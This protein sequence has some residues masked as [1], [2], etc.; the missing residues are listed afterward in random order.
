LS[1]SIEV[2]PS[3]LIPALNLNNAKNALAN[4]YN[5]LELFSNENQAIANLSRDGK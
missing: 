3:N 4:S 5:K 1:N 2:Q